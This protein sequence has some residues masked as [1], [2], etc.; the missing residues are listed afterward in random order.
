[1]TKQK[2]NPRLEIRLHYLC[3]NLM[4]IQKDLTSAC[5]DHPDSTCRKILNTDL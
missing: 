2:S 1:M 3:K 5:G 4:Q